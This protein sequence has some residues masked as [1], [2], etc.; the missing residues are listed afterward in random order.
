MSFVWHTNS[1][2]EVVSQQGNPVTLGHGETLS[3]GM[4]VLVSRTNQAGRTTL[5]SIILAMMIMV[6][7][8][9]AGPFEL[10]IPTDR[11]DPSDAVTPII[12]TMSE[13]TCEPNSIDTQND[14]GA[15]VLYS[16]RPTE[17]APVSTNDI[18]ML[19]ESDSDE[20]ELF[21]TRRRPK[22][23]A[24]RA[25]EQMFKEFASD[26]HSDNYNRRKTTHS[27]LSRVRFLRSLERISQSGG[28]V[29]NHTDDT[30]DENHETEVDLKPEEH[31]KIRRVVD[32]SMKEEDINWPVTLSMSADYDLNA[33][34]NYKEAMKLM[35]KEK[36]IA[37]C[38]AEMR[39]HEVNKTWTLV[40]RPKDR[41]P[42][43]CMWIFKTKDNGQAK[44][45]VVVFGNHQKEGI[46]YTETFSPTI[47]F[48][49]LRLALAIAA[50]QNLVVKQMDVSTA[51]LNGTLNEEIYML[52]PEGYKVPKKEKYVLKLNKS[53]Y[54]LKQAPMVWNQ[55]IADVIQKSGF[56]HSTADPCIFTI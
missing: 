24:A 27:K 29:M 41:K 3:A 20:T 55:T 10:V 42:L 13:T 26:Y 49:S 32:K 33:P 53:L 50:K 37:A 2:G 8:V 36:W 6:S 15:L 35:S 45:R 51:F 38:D 18:D 34:R 4:I 54:G 56:S 52:Q 46:D 48:T 9:F 19:S 11:L 14:N 44:A 43:G 23:R 40:P 1:L 17:T 39:A 16:D 30:D 31:I 28:I 7:S 21:D 5:S 12:T 47:R 22:R 25:A